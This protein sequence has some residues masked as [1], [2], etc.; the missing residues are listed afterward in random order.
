VSAP[1]P[2]P[3]GNRPPQSTDPAANPGAEV[4][5]ENPYVTNSFDP[6]SR[7]DSAATG[8]AAASAANPPLALDGYC[9]VTLAEDEKWEQGSRMWGARHRGR[10]YLFTSQQQQKKFLAD[11][12]RYSPVLSG[13][14]PTRLIDYGEPV[15]GHRRHGMWFR[16]KT[17]LFAD[18]DA[19][20][21]FERNPEYYAQKAHEIM[22]AGGR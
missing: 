10:T 5:F 3:S 13:Y 7:P 2:G 4:G 22:M 12:D 21:R 1:Q 17:Y 8:G 18:E 16:G 6:P 9:A 20:K 11:P 14:D 15:I 19:L